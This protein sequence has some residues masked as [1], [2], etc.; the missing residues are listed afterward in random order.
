MVPDD[1]NLQFLVM[2]CNLYSSYSSSTYT[3][4]IGFVLPWHLW[5]L[6]TIA[7]AQQNAQ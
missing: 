5:S 7:Q 2:S 1:K 3:M 6:S 4:Q